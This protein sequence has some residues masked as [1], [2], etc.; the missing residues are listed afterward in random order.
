[1]R[2]AGVFEHQDGVARAILDIAV[3]VPALA[4]EHT[5]LNLTEI[6]G[7]AGGGA[8]LERRRTGASIDIGDGGKHVIDGAILRVRIAGPRADGRARTHVRFNESLSS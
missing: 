4:T 8:G 6:I 3:T 5:E 2:A 7:I 1:M